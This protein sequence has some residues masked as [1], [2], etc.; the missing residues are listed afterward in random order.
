MVVSTRDI[1]IFD[2]FWLGYHHLRL[3]IIKYRGT[4]MWGCSLKNHQLKNVSRETFCDNK[5]K[6]YIF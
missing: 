1:V 6:I 5:I 3:Q 4:A 2:Y